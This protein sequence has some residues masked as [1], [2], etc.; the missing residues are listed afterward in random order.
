M[1][2]F[3]PDP[4]SRP[5]SQYRSS[6]WMRPVL[7]LDEHGSQE[8]PIRTAPAAAPVSV[9]QWLRDRLRRFGRTRP[10]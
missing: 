7:P 2:T 3:P 9:A 5:A 4:P 1:T 8:D 6:R 10:R